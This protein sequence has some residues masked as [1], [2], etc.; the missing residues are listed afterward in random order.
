MTYS[1]CTETES[2]LVQIPDPLTA[3]L[4]SILPSNLTFCNYNFFLKEG[5]F[6]YMGFIMFLFYILNECYLKWF[7]AAECACYKWFPTCMQGTFNET[8]FI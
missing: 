4:G 7:I 1:V 2:L 5:V 6:K 3:C 8:S